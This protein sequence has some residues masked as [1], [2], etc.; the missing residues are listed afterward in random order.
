MMLQIFSFAAAVYCRY[1][2]NYIK[3]LVKTLFPFWLALKPNQSFYKLWTS[4]EFHKESV[5]A[6]K[7]VHVF[8]IVENRPKIQ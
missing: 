6:L 3:T 1:T 2:L 8:I 5:Y 4:F 7:F